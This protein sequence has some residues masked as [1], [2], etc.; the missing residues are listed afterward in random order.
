[1]SITL[2]RPMFRKGGQAEEGIMEL[3][4]PRRNYVKGTTLQD[5]IAGSGLDPETQ[6]IIETTSKITRFCIICNNITRIID[7][8]SSRCARFRY[9][10]IRAN[11]MKLKLKSNLT[12]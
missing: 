6:R 12:N 5:I 2:K 9:A 8:I 3:A 4:A 1:M 11:D 7:P 10:L